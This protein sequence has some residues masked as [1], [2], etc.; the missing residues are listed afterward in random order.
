ML[1]ERWL[2]GGNMAGFLGDPK[3]GLWDLR[4]KSRDLKS[5]YTAGRVGDSGCMEH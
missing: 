4:K 5:V 1:T 2:Y 3:L